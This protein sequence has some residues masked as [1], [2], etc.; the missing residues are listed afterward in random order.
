M[1][2]VDKLFFGS[3]LLEK[4]Y[5]NV[6]LVSIGRNCSEVSL[7]MKKYTKKKQQIGNIS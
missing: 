7:G 6:T 1:F 3:N 5:L 2:Q 4:C